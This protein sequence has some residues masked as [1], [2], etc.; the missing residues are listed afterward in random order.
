MSPKK[1][2]PPKPPRKKREQI[3]LYISQ[4]EKEEVEK[5]RMKESP[6]KRT[7]AYIRDVAVDHAEKV[8]HKK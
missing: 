8:N 5:A 2:Q 6:D 3:S 7:G 1:G 4:E